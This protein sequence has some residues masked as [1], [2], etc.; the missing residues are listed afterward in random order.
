[1][2]TK[3]DN[4]V[5]KMTFDNAQF[6]K[7][8]K[9]TMDTLTEFEK[10]LKMDGASAGF[11][12]VKEAAQNLDLSALNG[13]A[14]GAKNKFQ[15]LKDS[16]LSRFSE[17]KQGADSTDFSGLT[18]NAQSAASG[19]VNAMGEVDMSQVGSEAERAGQGFSV[20]E[21]IAVGALLR[22]GDEI[23]N[24]VTNKLHGMLNTINDYTFKPIMEGFKEYET[25][26]GSIQTIMANTGMD[27]NNQ[28]DIDIVNDALDELNHYA[29]KTIYNFTEMTRNIGTFT[30]AG[31]DLDTAVSSI[32]GIAN[33]AALSG[34]T[35]QQASTAMY[36]L[37][38]A[39]AAG[40]LK[41]QDWNSVV[42]AGMGGRVFQEQLKATARAHGIAVD[43]MIEANGSFRESL[44]E[45]WITSDILTETLQNMTIQY[46]EVGDKAY[47]AAKE[48]LIAS[49]YTEEAAVETLRLAKASEE[50]A[51]KVR[52]WSQLW[53]TV[54]EA[55]GSQWTSIIGNLI[56][57]FGQATD[58][59]TR[60]SDAISGGVNSLLGGLVTAA[61]VYNKSGAYYLIMGGEQWDEATKKM[62]R[63]P[64]ALDW[65]IQAISGP[66]GAIKDAFDSVFSFGDEK[67]LENGSIWSDKMGEMFIGIAQAINEFTQS[68]VANDDVLTAIRQVAEAVFTVFKIGIQVVADLVGIFFKLVEVIRIFVDPLIN[69]VA[70]IIGIAAGA[71][72]DLMNAI[73]GFID[74]I[75]VAIGYSSSIIEA[76]RNIVQWLVQLIDIPGKL[77]AVADFIH[78]IFWGIYDFFNIPGILMGVVNAFT[79]LGNALSLIFKMITGDLNDKALNESILNAGPW[80]IAFKDAINTVKGALSTLA[81]AFD[82]VLTPIR[83]FFN[84]LN[85]KAKAISPEA[86][87]R[88]TWLKNYA[89]LVKNTVANVASFISNIFAPIVNLIS[90]IA[91][92]VPEMWN[93]F[94]NWGPV[95]TVLSMFSDAGNNILNFFTGIVDNAGKASDGIHSAFDGLQNWNPFAWFNE[96][97][98]YWHTHTIDQIVADAQRIKDDFVGNIVGAFEYLKTATPK[99]MSIDFFNQWEK[100]VSDLLVSEWGLWGIINKIDSIFPGFRKSVEPFAE[101]LSDVVLDIYASVRDFIQP[102]ADA[103]EDIPSFFANL[104]AKIK[105]SIV[106]GIT[107][108]NPHTLAGNFLKGFRGIVD[109]FKNTFPSI[110][111]PLENVYNAISGFLS[112][113]TERADGFGGVFKNV[114]TKITDFLTGLPIIGDVFKS[115]SDWFTYFTTEVIP[116]GDIF[117]DIKQ[118]VKDFLG[119]VDPQKVG[120]NVSGALE[121]V[122]DKAEEAKTGFAG[123][124]DAIDPAGIP[125]KLSNFIGT[126]KDDVKT[127]FDEFVA[128]ITDWPTRLNEI[129]Q[130]LADA[131]PE[132]AINKFADIVERVIKNKVLLSTSNLFDGLGELARSAG[133]YM[134]GDNKSVIQKALDDIRSIAISLAIVAGALWIVSTI[135]QDRLWQSIKALGIMGLVI[136]AMDTLGS[137]VK[138]KTNVDGVGDDLLKTSASLLVLSFAL[139]SMVKTLDIFWQADPNML[140]GGLIKVAGVLIV[141]YGIMKKF[142]NG[143]SL[144]AGAGLALLSIGLNLMMGPI[145]TMA[146]LFDGKTI[147]EMFQMGLGIAALGGFVMILAAA[148]NTVGKDG[149][150]AGA[151]MLIMSVAVMIIGEAIKNLVGLDLVQLGVA[152]IALA[153]IIAVFGFMVDFTR[154]ADLAKSAKALLIYSVALGVI[155]FSLYQLASLKADALWAAGIALVGL[156]AAIGVLTTVTDAKDIVKT[157]AALLIFG[158][159]VA[160]M[161]LGLRLLQGIEWPALLVGGLAI[162]GLMLALGALSTLTKESDLVATS[163]SLVL[164]GAALV[165]MAAALSILSGLDLVGPVIALGALILIF[166][167]L[168]AVLASIPGSVVVLIAFSLALIGVGAACYLIATAMS[169]AVD[170]LAKFLM[171]GPSLTMF[172]NLV[173]QNVGN[174]ALAAI[175]LGAL[176]IGLGALGI[177]LIGLGAGLTVFGIGATLAGTGLTLITVGIR[178]FLTLLADLPVLVQNAITGI[179]TFI[180][181]FPTMLG[182]AISTIWTWFTTEVLPK[183]PEFIG[184]AIAAIGGFVEP[185]MGWVTET[186]IPA[187]GEFISGIGAKL[188]E[189]APMVLD[190]ITNTAIPAMGDFIKNFWNW[191]Q[192]EGWPAAVE[193]IKGFIAKLG[194]FAGNLGNWVI[195]DA[196]PAIGKAIGDLIH[197]FQEIWPD[198]VEWG[199]SIPSKIMEGLGNLAEWAGNVGDEIAHGIADGLSKGIDWIV[200]A[201]TSLGNQAMDAI[202]DFFG[203]ASPSKLMRDE[204]GRYL[205]LGLADGIGKYAFSVINQAKQMANSTTKAV[206][207]GFGSIDSVSPTITPVLNMNSASMGLSNYLTDL[208]QIDFS[209]AAS[210]AENLDANLDMTSLSTAFD[211]QSHE[212]AMLRDQNQK[213]L[214]EISALRTDVAQY[215]DTMSKTSMIL[216]SGALVGAMTPQIDRALGTR[217]VQAERGVY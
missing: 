49:G 136:I 40:S 150:K 115:L 24:L 168:T 21:T 86:E 209:G 180:T 95:A 90:A 81:S 39:I 210:F 22:V 103:S 211:N 91:E 112:D 142:A 208:G 89:E 44:Q 178:N 215:N 133:K 148:L 195:N 167:G 164:F 134:K 96:V 23:T 16:V 45:G 77:R 93:A 106:N 48:Q 129:L 199:K 56:G 1:M 20:F 143:D 194:E 10:K 51:T 61:E 202:C 66:L 203:I 54:K 172:V 19:V 145:V 88:I 207:D 198:I 13:K 216:D 26:M 29:D 161:S 146:H 165:I 132:D 121:L 4:R 128:Y 34:S 64:G 157:S 181:N 156:I 154:G 14:E 213:L 201:V 84:I 47:E 188:Q 105:D 204:V 70:T 2:S 92:K 205:D 3:V 107:N 200:N 116:V 33:M 141:L 7:G 99:Q 135:P 79:S 55:I 109:W 76:L 42:N 36:Q 153:G 118:K 174:F 85:N 190:W 18:S 46:D 152:T 65:L 127:K 175:G 184:Q 144:K 98:E 87:K 179:V 97:A 193:F 186:A 25:Q 137:I 214:N 63:I 28:A 17:M 52:T 122:G 110:A 60:L 94:L 6:Q 74:P 38:Q 108:L 58:M 53:D 67:E 11:N 71:L 147:G 30:A 35:S 43:E 158:L 100:L 163:A 113:V 78:A 120:D 169:I 114:G 217:M 124:V 173:A 75:R 170:A 32:Q 125:G 119:I 31:V 126:L 183:I 27:F 176:A 185:F 159:A 189:W 171:L 206:N 57:D 191:I 155:S 8:I 140:V 196:L 62:E 50:A 177:A 12:K 41:L 160:A 123:L 212:I 151:G 72:T 162:A 37:S 9:N 5:V 139:R 73:M 59:F 117:D 104:F 111:E 101:V 149:I 182:E 138:A 102:I 130:G 131:I 187:I 192:T 166:G 15:E 83:N 69:I 82:W 80:A 68:L 197:K